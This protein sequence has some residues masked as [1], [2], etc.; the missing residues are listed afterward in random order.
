MRNRIDA[1]KRL[2]LAGLLAVTSAQVAPAQQDTFNWFGVPNGQV[3]SEIDATNFVVHPGASFM[4]TGL[5]NLFTTSDT[6]NYTNMGFMFGAPGFDFVTWPAVIGARHAASR[7][8][9]TTPT[10]RPK[11]RRRSTPPRTASDGR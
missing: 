7:S 2:L 11:F 3:P 8:W 9:T 10:T 5:G 4:V 1:M 6:L